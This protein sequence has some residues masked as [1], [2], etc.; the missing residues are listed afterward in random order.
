MVEPIVVFRELADGNVVAISNNYDAYAVN[1]DKVN[2][3]MSK[4]KELTG[5]TQVEFNDTFRQICKDRVFYA[6]EPV[7]EFGVNNEPYV[8]EVVECVLL[9]NDK[10]AMNVNGTITICTAEDKNAMFAT[11]DDALTAA[12]ENAK[13]VNSKYLDVLF[14]SRKI[15]KST[16]NKIND[17]IDKALN[18]KNNL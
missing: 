7:T 10:V 17:K 5:G 16:I 6:F 3:Y 2:E 13:E 11:H 4:L 9:T 15:A 18:F 12:K 14:T 8:P 1:A